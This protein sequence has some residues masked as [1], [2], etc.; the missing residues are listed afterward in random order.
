[1]LGQL[2]AEWT[3]LHQARHTQQH[4]RRWAHTHTILA[5]CTRIGDILDMIDASSR[6]TTDQILAALLDIH[7]HGERLAG[8]IL[9]QA[10]LPA[11]TRRARRCRMPDDIDSHDARIQYT[12]TAFWAVITGL[13]ARQNLASRM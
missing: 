9:L 4:V 12:I 3:H 11:L 10:M 2:T 6:P 5:G 8:R 7:Q 1:T 13:A